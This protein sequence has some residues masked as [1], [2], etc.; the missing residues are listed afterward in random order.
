MQQQSDDARFLELRSVTTGYG[1]VPVVRNANMAFARGAITAVIGSNGAGKSTAI[2]AAAGLLPIWKGQVKVNGVD[3]THEAPHKR[4]ARGVAFVPQGRIVLPEM[5]VRENLDVGAYI[6]GNDRARF[7]AALAR[8]VR[9]FPVIGKRM[10]QLAGTMSGGEQQ[11]LA[12]ARALMTDPTAIILDEPSLGLSP[13]L[14]DQ[15]FEKLTMLAAEGLTVIMVEQKAS[16]ALAIAHSGY[17]MHTGQ[18]VYS[19]P[20]QELLDNPNVQRLFLGEVPEEIDRLLATLENE[21]PAHA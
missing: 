14:V 13:K 11:M 18:V 3:V 5:T 16:R 7:D 8:M 15:V 1:D 2:K 6:L 12:I 19:G 17:V 10:N 9:I 21:E 4:L 20:A